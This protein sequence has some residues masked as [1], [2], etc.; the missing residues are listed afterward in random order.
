MSSATGSGSGMQQRSELEQQAA[1]AAAPAG[2]D[3]SSDTVSGGGGSGSG[4][5]ATITHLQRAGFLALL[6]YVAW[7]SLILGGNMAY[8]GEPI[9]V[10]S[11][12]LPLHLF[13]RLFRTVGSLL[14]FALWAVRAAT[15]RLLPRHFDQASTLLRAPLAIYLVQSAIRVAIYQLHVAG[16]IFSPQRWARDNTSH[17]PHV[18]SDHVLL[19]SAVHAGLTSE[20]LLPML[21][22]WHAKTTGGGRTFLRLYS[23]AAGTLAVLVSAECY[24]TARYFHP[25]GEIFLAAVLGFAVFQAPLL[26]YAQRVF[27]QHGAAQVVA[28]GT[29]SGRQHSNLS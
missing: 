3:G 15:T 2:L 14:L 20:A 9:L 12:D 7:F 6:C 16:Y 27:Q 29:G 23:A 4:G 17:P 10:K 26:L 22:R 18:M 11:K 13:D 28:G 21:N 5:S 24:F 1:A 19:A 8:E 25:P